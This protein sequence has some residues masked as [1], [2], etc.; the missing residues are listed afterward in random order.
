MRDAAAAWH[1]RGGLPV[2][3]ADLR[4]RLVAR[5]CA[6]GLVSVS[7]APFVADAALRV[8]REAMRTPSVE[9]RRAFHV[10]NEEYEDGAAYPEGSPDY[11]W[12]AMLAASPLRE[13]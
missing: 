13:E 2:T 1:E 12:R 11:Q 4:D 3:P 7:D 5:L 6:L 10:A 8:V 9:M